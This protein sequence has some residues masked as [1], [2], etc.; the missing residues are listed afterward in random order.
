MSLKAGIEVDIAV[1]GSKGSADCRKATVYHADAKIVVLSQTS[2]PLTVSL[3]HSPVVISFVS[4]SGSA[5][6][7]TG[8][9]GKISGLVAQYPL[10]SG[11]FMP[12]VV[13]EEVRKLEG[14]TLR[15]SSRVRPGEDGG[16]ALVV[17]GRGAKVCDISM[18]GINFMQPGSRNVHS[19]GDVLDIILMP[20]DTII[21]AKAK[22]IRTS[23]KDGMQF[24][25]ADFISMESGAEDIFGM[26]LFALEMRSMSG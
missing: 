25:A 18:T 14:M 6:V 11:Q 8:Y 24:T 16:L 9:S 10:A 17:R 19:P 13:L 22:V 2:P 26:K 7:R 21:E 12:A 20:D 3:L 1:K 4:T 15:R 5:P 23:E